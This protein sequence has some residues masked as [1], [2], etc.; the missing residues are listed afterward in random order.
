MNLRKDQ[1]ILVWACVAALAIWMVT[2]LRF[3]LLPLVYFNTHVHELCHALAT[4]LTGGKVAFV[5]VFADGSGVTQT[6]GGSALLISSAG[7]VGSAIV[8]GFLVY[9]SRTAESARKMLWIAMA[10]LTLGMLFFVRGD[11]VGVVSGLGWIVALCLGA[12]FLKGDSAVFAGQFLGIQQCLTSAHSFLALITVTAS[13][14]GH[15]DAANLEQAT[16][17]PAILWSIGWLVFGLFAIGLG[18]RAS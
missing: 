12:A 2:P 4:V 1:K 8:G 15:S 14:A 9:F 5:E 10:F 18:I 17:V 6:R 7:Y 3:L 16:R 11:T 13:D